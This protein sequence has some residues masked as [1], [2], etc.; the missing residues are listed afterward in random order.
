[1]YC[2]TVCL[3]SLVTGNYFKENP[4]ETACRNRGSYEC[5]IVSED[6][7]PYKIKIECDK[8]DIKEPYFSCRALFESSDK[9]IKKLKDKHRFFE[10]DI[11]KAY[12]SKFF[13]H[14]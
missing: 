4:C 14:I 12:L 9:N 6:M 5:N 11:I 2:K 7:V 10:K 3:L 8:Y 13:R 1:M